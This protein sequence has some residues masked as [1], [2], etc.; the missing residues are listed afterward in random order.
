MRR[1]GAWALV[2]GLLASGLPVAAALA[3]EGRVVKV[4]PKT[5]PKPAPSPQSPE[6]V[7]PPAPPMSTV[8]GVGW[9]RAP[10]RDDIGRFYPD[11]AQRL[12]KEGRATITCE[13]RAN[14][15]LEG[16][17]V[18]SEDP[19]D[20]GFGDA[21]IKLSRLFKLKPAIRD[22]LPVDRVPVGLLIEFRISGGDPIVSATL[23]EPPAAQTSVCYAAEPSGGGNCD[24]FARAT[25]MAMDARLP[26]PS[27]FGVND[28]DAE[29]MSTP[30]EISNK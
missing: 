3:Q 1:L 16:C 24:E 30:D 9:E 25:G 2:G 26:P 7:A 14:G 4:L 21:A 29:L 17:E 11:R 8:G 20:L 12:E 18:S 22:G 6:T 5:S 23:I 10:Y 28:L 15:T 27:V 13:V 19:A